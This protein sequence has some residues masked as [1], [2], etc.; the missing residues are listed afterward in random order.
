[1][2]ISLIESYQVQDVRHYEL[3]E[4]KIESDLKWKFPP[5]PP[6]AVQCVLK[7]AGKWWFLASLGCGFFPDWP[8]QWFVLG[9]PFAW[10]RARLWHGSTMG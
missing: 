10:G 6:T 4:S 3:D 7:H 5:I 9:G 1:M 2:K 8:A